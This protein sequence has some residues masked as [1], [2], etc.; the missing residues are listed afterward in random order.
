MNSVGSALL[1][2]PNRMLGADAPEEQRAA[3]VGCE[4][5][6]GTLCWYTGFCCVGID[7]DER[8]AQHSHEQPNP[9]RRLPGWDNTCTRGLWLTACW[10]CLLTAR[11]GGCLPAS[12][13]T[14]GNI[15]NMR[16][17]ALQLTDNGGMHTRVHGAA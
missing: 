5:C 10:P 13:S 15:F 17:S 9:Y 11:C 2:A 8:E 7:E 14:W 4:A 6:C 1:Y 16:S 12:E 3:C